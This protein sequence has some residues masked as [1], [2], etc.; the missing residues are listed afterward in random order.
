MP[1]CAAC[2]DGYLQLST[3]KGKNYCLE[4]YEE[5]RFDIVKPLKK[6]RVPKV[7]GPPAEPLCD[8]QYH[9]YGVCEIL[10]RKRKK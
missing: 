6:I 4:C 2:K 10:G 5:L 1:R 7:S 3:W 8:S 9:G